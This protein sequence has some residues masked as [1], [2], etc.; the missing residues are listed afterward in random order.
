M[1]LRVVP[2][3]LALKR[4]DGS[5]ILAPLG[6]GEFHDLGVGL[7]GTDDPVVRPD[8]AHPLPLLNHVRVGFLDEL[9]HSAEGFPPPVPQ[10]GDSLGDELRGR[11]AFARARLFHVLILDWGYLGSGPGR[12]P[13]LIAFF[14]STPILASST[15]VSFFS[16]NEVGHM[17]PSSSFAWSLNPN[18]AYLALNFCALWKKQITLPPMA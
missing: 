2:S 11:R 8:R 13:Q 6:E 12:N 3:R 9:A 16:A 18:V 15:A 5:G 1:A 10:L 14:T 4:R 7:A 17:T